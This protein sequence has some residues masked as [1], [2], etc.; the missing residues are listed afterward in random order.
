MTK[1]GY[2]QLTSH[3]IKKLEKLGWPKDIIKRTT[4][5][6]EKEMYKLLRLGN[7]IIK[8]EKDNVNKH[9]IS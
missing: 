8:K 6:Q 3:Q 4:S 1:K 9:R 7:D 5:D 2:S